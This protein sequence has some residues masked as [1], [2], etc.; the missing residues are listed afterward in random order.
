MMSSALRTV[1]GVRALLLRQDRQRR[2]RYRELTEDRR[3]IQDQLARVEWR[4]VTRHHDSAS[5]RK[6]LRVEAQPGFLNLSCRAVRQYDEGIGLVRNGGI[7]ASL[8]DII[9][10]RQAGAVRETA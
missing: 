1:T 9:L 7:T 3:H 8:F 4:D 10:H 5:R 6:I 2:Q